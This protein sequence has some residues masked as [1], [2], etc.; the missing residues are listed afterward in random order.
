LESVE[1]NTY[2][3]EK[4]VIGEL[5][6]EKLIAVVNEEVGIFEIEQKRQAIGE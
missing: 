2:G 6:A 1:R 3:K 4:I 5:G